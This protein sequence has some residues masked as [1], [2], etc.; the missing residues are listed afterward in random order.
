M[1]I[2]QIVTPAAVSAVLLAANSTFATTSTWTGNG[3]LWDAPANYLSSPTFSTTNDLNFAAINTPLPVVLSATTVGTINVQSLYFGSTSSTGTSTESIT[4][5]GDGTAGDTIL[6]LNK[7]IYLPSPTSTVVKF[8]SDLTLNFTNGTHTVNY[9]ANSSI[10]SMPAVLPVVVIASKLTGGGA[11]TN[12]TGSYTP[13]GSTSSSAPAIVLSNNSNTLDSTYNIGGLFSYTSIN[14]AGA[15]AGASAL[16][17]SNASS[18]AIT[19]SNGGRFSYV[20][21]G[22][23]TTNRSIIY[24]GANAINNYATSASNLTFTGVI[25]ST[26]TSAGTLSFGVS[27]G[28][29]ITLASGIGNS[30]GTGTPAWS[31]VK[32]AGSAYYDANGAFRTGDGNGTL[33]LTGAFTYTGTTTIA[34]GTLQVGNGTTGNL[35][36]TGGTYSALNFTTS[37]GTFVVNEASGVSQNMG[38]LTFTA[39][40]GNVQSINN[41]GNS[42]LSFTSLA[43]STKGATGNFVTTGGVNGSTNKIALTSQAAGVLGARYFYGGNS[44]SASFAYYDNTGYVRGI[45]YG[46]DSNTQNNTSGAAFTSGN[47]VQV[48]TTS[49]TGQ[50]SVNIGTLQIADTSTVSLATGATL[51]V[52]GILKSGGN[53]STISS[54]TI[55]TGGANE[56]VIRVDQ[57]SDTLTIASSLASSSG[58]GLTKSGLGTLKLTGNNSLTGAVYINSGVLQFQNMNLSNGYGW[59]LGNAKIESLSG[60]N[61]TSSTLSLVGSGTVQVDTGTLTFTNGANLT[62]GG[63][64]TLTVGGTGNVVFSG[65]VTGAGAG[66]TKFGSGTVT[67]SNAANTYSG[68]TTV[69]GGQL[70][71]TGALAVDTGVTVNSGGVLAGT[72]TAAG[73]VVI[74]GGGLLNAGTIGTVGTL[75]TGGL[76]LASG[77]LLGVDLVGDTVDKISVNG[78]A[79]L[80][81]AISVNLT[82]SQTLGKYVL[83]TTTGALSGGSALIGAADYRLSA[84]SSELDLIHRATIGSVTA[85]TTTTSLLAG[86]STDVTFKVSNSA[87]TSSDSLSVT[88]SAGTN[89]HGAVGTAVSVAAG[90]TSANISGLSFSSATAGAGQEGTFTV[91][92]SNATNGG[93]TA[94]VS[95]DVYDRANLTSAGS[96]STGSVETY[97][98]TNAK[99]SSALR[100]A[101]DVT[102][103]SLNTNVTGFT[104]ANAPGLVASNATA[105]IASFD[106]SDKLN[107][108]YHAT[109]NIGATSTTASGGAIGGVTTG[110]AG[111]SVSL[112]AVVSGNTGAAGVTKVAGIVAGGSF[113]G[114]NLTSSGLAYNTTVALLGGS[115]TVDTTLSVTFNTATN[116]AINDSVNRVADIV[117]ISGVHQTGLKGYDNSTLTDLFVVQLSYSI[118]ETGEVYVAYYDTTLGEFVSAVS[119]NSNGGA[120]LLEGGS[121]S[122]YV[123]TWNSAYSLGSYGYDPTT[124]TA[125]AVVDHN[126]DYTVLTVVPEPSTWAMLVGGV[127]M[128]AF[129]QRLRRRQ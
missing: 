15:S 43:A 56:L 92:D 65:A 54:G 126:S 85:S 30:T 91:N 16:G 123:G 10:T 27:T 39:G 2:R 35:I 46:T 70:A 111:T 76:T 88:A 121:G 6:N 118:E 108:T 24:S 60:T 117:S 40:E 47:N 128:L 26:A 33:L 93:Q 106:S 120:S 14:N 62:S 94:T 50:A 82:G 44:S 57:A 114:Y 29:T 8:G 12:F 20:G 3:T 17:I 75:T 31:L 100:A 112:S 4:I 19:F 28:N 90:E 5:N 116:L 83:L 107:G 81:G 122:Y 84:S 55:T 109:A 13:L 105:A 34:S 101:A 36:N 78:N 63:V 79:A 18:G 125:W 37:G 38:S 49:V 22:N 21:S 48:S 68:S 42:T 87:P 72:G 110:D 69:N 53:A 129:G 64:N 127:G 71:V 32:S 119:G 77:A 98:L 74:N 51:T 99:G 9:Q 113:A 23:Q 41:G 95:V 67:L 97:S 80:S 1:R 102:S 7:N 103:V 45:N 89:V 58:A 104:A 11:G 66:L 61:S 73:S 96:T 25:S 124:H 115:S 86:S 52:G 59:Y